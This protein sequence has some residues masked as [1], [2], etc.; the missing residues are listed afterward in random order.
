MLIQPVQQVLQTHHLQWRV[1][2]C[3]CKC[4]QGQIR[5]SRPSQRL[6]SCTTGGGLVALMEAIYH[7]RLTG[8][9]HFVMMEQQQLVECTLL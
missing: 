1:F 3:H 6:T 4:L 9:H 8:T 5:L 7:Q 2:T